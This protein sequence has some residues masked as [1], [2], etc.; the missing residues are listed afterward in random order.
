[1][2]KT[3]LD[4]KYAHFEAILEPRCRKKKLQVTLNSSMFLSNVAADP[5]VQLQI[6]TKIYITTP[7]LRDLTGIWR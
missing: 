1:M 3:W 6:D 2:Y 5:Q 4:N 7:K